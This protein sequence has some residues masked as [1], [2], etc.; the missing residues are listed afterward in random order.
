MGSISLAYEAFGVPLEIY[1]IRTSFGSTHPLQLKLRFVDALG[2]YLNLRENLKNILFLYRIRFSKCLWCFY[3]GVLAFGLFLLVVLLSFS[4]Q[5]IEKSALSETHSIAAA[6]NELNRR[7]LEAMSIPLEAV[8]DFVTKY[9]GIDSVTKSELDDFLIREKRELSSTSIKNIVVVDK[10]GD[11]VGNTFIPGISHSFKEDAEFE[12]IRSQ[13]K[14][15][16]LST[17]TSPIDQQKVIVLIKIL[18]RGGH[19]DGLI[20]VSKPWSD[21]ELLYKSLQIPPEI[22]YTMYRDDGNVLYS[23]NKSGELA[24]KDLGFLHQSR[25]NS[26]ENLN[27]LMGLGGADHVGHYKFDSE[28]NDMIY[29]GY[30]VE[31]LFTDWISMVRISCGLFFAFMF[32]FGLLIRLLQKRQEDVE[33]NQRESNKRFEIINKINHEVEALTGL[34]FLKE[35]CQQIKNIFN[36]RSVSIGVWM[37]EHLNTLKCLVNVGESE[38]WEGMNCDIRGTPFE[39]LKP[40]GRFSCKK[41]AYQMFLETSLLGSKKIEACIGMVFQGYGGRASGVLMITS[42]IEIFE[43]DLIEFVLSDFALRAGS[44]IDRIRTD[45]IRKEIE[46]LRRQIEQRAQQSE[47]LETIGALAEGIAHDFNNII[48]IILAS[49]EK[50]LNLHK[51]STVDFPYLESIKRAC[52]RAR[53]LVSQIAGFSHKNEHHS[54]QLVVKKIFDDMLDF[55]RS[56]L[57]AQVHLNLNLGECAELTIFADLNQIQQVLVNLCVYL[58]RFLGTEGG[59]VKISLRK[60]KIKG[61]LFIRWHF[62]LIGAVQNHSDEVKDIDP[63]SVNDLGLVAV[64]RIVTRHLGFI[65]TKKEL[66]QVASF[67]IFLPA[68]CVKEKKEIPEVY[69]F[70]LAPK[71]IIVDDEPE[72]GSLIKD[73]LEAEGLK[74]EAFSNAIKALK[75]FSEKQDEYFLIISDL[76]MPEMSGFAFAR[77]VRE[78]SKTISLLLWSGYQ[79]IFE[80]DLQD[81]NIQVLSK[82]V[83]VQKL[84]MMIQ[85][86]LSQQYALGILKEPRAPEPGPEEHP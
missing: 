20:G 86:E 10:Y 60:T 55:L 64:Q 81:L 51:D 22:A 35:L 83:D 84:L 5:Q 63:L 43:M 80:E 9:G 26:M 54:R 69:N 34:L 32:A 65:E 66:D 82:P 46:N 13:K 71:V 56:T 53:H 21:F 14:Y 27:P 7:Q 72:I 41:R 18:R 44:E 52:H 12:Y 75:A 30:R 33:E 4:Y 25:L 79:Q 58:A 15:T 47:N 74:V 61:Q 37:P 3:A 31:D 70:K 38:W 1:A 49:T 16:I 73:L 2:D 6:L 24:E 19:F 78:I 68:V 85:S 17:Y 59:E 28:F 48:A 11:L 39:H 77:K 23:H 36:V 45:E 76:S 50:M 67:E 40:G 62:T 42:E 57:P 8:A 29:V